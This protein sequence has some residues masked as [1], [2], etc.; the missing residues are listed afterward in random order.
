MRDFDGFVRTMHQDRRLTNVDVHSSIGDPA[1]IALN[2]QLASA[3][4]GSTYSALRESSISAIFMTPLRNSLSEHKEAWGIDTFLAFDPDFLSQSLDQHLDRAE[5][6]GVGH[7]V[8]ASPGMAE[9]LNH[10]PRVA[11]EAVFG[12]WRAYALRTPAPTAEVLQREPAVFFG[13]APF[14]KR[15]TWSYD[16]TRLQE[17]IFFRGRFDNIVARAHDQ[18]LDT[19]PDLDRFRTAIIADYRYRDLDRAYLRLKSYSDNNTLICIAAADPLFRR[20][21]ALPPSPN[22]HI[23]DRLSGRVEDIQPLRH[24][25]QSIL[26]IAARSTRGVTGAADQRVREVRLA[27]GTIRV[28]LTGRAAAKMPILIRVSYFPYWRRVDSEEVVY[29]VTPT[30]MLTYADSDVALEFAADTFTW[31]GLSLSLLAVLSAGAIL[32]RPAGRSPE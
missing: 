28:F 5:Y 20:L 30:F 3:H 11:L 6:M 13:P 32:T 24:Q 18:A 7:L 8:T 16:Y 29:M 25:L 4:L 9:R 2:A 19:S 26:A 22:L 23:V 14:R 15:S 27:D 1:Y 21:S 10:N 12:D 17:E 31:L